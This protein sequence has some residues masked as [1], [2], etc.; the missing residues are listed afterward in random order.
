MHYYVT[1]FKFS[2]TPPSETLLSTGNGSGGGLEVYMKRTVTIFLALL[3]IITM[4]ACTQ[5]SAT[6]APE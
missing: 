1:Y 5:N 3:I 6:K 4:N 2:Q